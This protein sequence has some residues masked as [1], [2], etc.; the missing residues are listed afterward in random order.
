MKITKAE[1]SLWTF[2]NIFKSIISKSNGQTIVIGNRGTLV[3]GTLNHYGV[4]KYKSDGMIDD[5]DF[6][7]DT[8]YELK[9]LPSGDYVLDK[10][11]RPITVEQQEQIL[12]KVILLLKDSKWKIELDK[13]DHHKI[14]KI[15]ASTSLWLEDAD[16]KYLNAFPH[17]DIF[18]DQVTQTLV[19]KSYG[20]SD[21]IKTV[22]MYLMFAGL[23]C[24]AVVQQKADIR[25]FEHPEVEIQQDPEIETE[26]DYENKLINETVEEFEDDFDPMSI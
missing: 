12:Q 26:D 13:G 9:Q 20:L 8:F 25:D 23:E 21:D 18:A 6:G 4:F 3:I 11:D 24:E 15:V 16:I 17:I 22:E 19:L 14:A 10:K 5:Y 7:S 1:K 2:L